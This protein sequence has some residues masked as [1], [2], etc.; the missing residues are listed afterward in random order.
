[1]FI[2]NYII[3]RW[4][5]AIVNF[6]HCNHFWYVQFWQMFPS[7]SELELYHSKM[8]PARLLWILNIVT[9]FDTYNFDRCFHPILDFN[10]FKSLNFL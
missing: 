4:D 3:V 2:W 9:I 7:N 6:E 8:G 5:T 1:M 10:F